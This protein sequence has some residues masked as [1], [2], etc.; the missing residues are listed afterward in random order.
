[1]GPFTIFKEYEIQYC[2]LTWVLSTYSSRPPVPQK[3]LFLVSVFNKMRYLPWFL[4]AWSQELFGSLLKIL[5][6]PS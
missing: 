2:K 3:N 5:F 6:L 4:L 1:M